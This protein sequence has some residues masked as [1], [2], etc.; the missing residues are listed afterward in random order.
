VYTRSRRCFWKV[1]CERTKIVSASSRRE[2]KVVGCTCFAEREANVPSIQC[3]LRLNESIQQCGYIWTAYVN[4]PAASLRPQPSLYQPSLSPDQPPQLYRPQPSPTALTTIP[5][6]RRLPLSYPLAVTRNAKPLVL[7]PAIS[8]LALRRLSLLLL[9]LSLCV[10][11]QASVWSIM[12]GH[13]QS[14]ILHCTAHHD[15]FQ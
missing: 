13:H 11:R 12:K 4:L 15:G 9:L 7:A 6:R 5:P 1:P 3:R 10:G 2:K 14:T 8:F